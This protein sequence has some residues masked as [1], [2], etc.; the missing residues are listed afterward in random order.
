MKTFLLLGGIALI[1]IYVI[2]I[3]NKLVS[4]KARFENAFAQIEVQLKRRYD[5][6]PNLVET[7]KGY[8]SHERGT[9]EEVINARNKAMTALNAAAAHPGSMD[10]LAS[11]AGAEQGLAASLGKLDV[12]VEAYP[13]LKADQTMSDLMEELTATENR[14]AFARQAYNDAVTDYNVYR[15]SFPQ[16]MFAPTFGHRSDAGLLA[17]DDSVKIRQAPDVSFS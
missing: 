7:A 11:L 1:V 12:V 10:K 6:I 14:V 5:L 17:F 16:V 15:Q 9:L 13:E 2:S 4:L 3:Y 8:L